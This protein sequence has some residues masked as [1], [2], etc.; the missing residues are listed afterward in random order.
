MDFK[1]EAPIARRSDPVGSHKAAAALNNSGRRNTQKETVLQALRQHPDKTSAEL[2][3]LSGELDRVTFARR[4]PD[5]E[6]DGY[7]ARSGERLCAATG[8]TCV[9]WKPVAQFDEAEAVH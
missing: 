9:T 3:E 2:H 6:T 7:A 1:N 5:L 8:H 4:L